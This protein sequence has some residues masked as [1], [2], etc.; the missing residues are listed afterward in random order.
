MSTREQYRNSIDTLFPWLRILDGARLISSSK[1]S[2]DNENI[3]SSESNL[4]QTSCVEVQASFVPLSLESSTQAT[5][6]TD[7]EAQAGSEAGVKCFVS[8]QTQKVIN[9]SV[10]L[11]TDQ[12]ENVAHSVQTEAEL[13]DKKEFDILYQS[14]KAME[15]SHSS[16]AVLLEIDALKLRI[17]VLENDKRELLH[18][19]Q[20]LTKQVQRN[21][22][23]VRIESLEKLIVAQERIVA[24]SSGGL[25]S[26][27]LL[28]AWRKQV[29]ALM[30]QN[31]TT[32]ILYNKG[33]FD[34]QRECEQLKLEL[35]D[36]ENKIEE[37]LVATK[38]S[39]QHQ[40]D[41]KNQVLDL[42]SR[43]ESLQHEKA[44]VE[45]LL[46]QLAAR[47]SKECYGIERIGDK[48]GR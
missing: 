27:D 19:N 22:G 34:L 20:M 47:Y 6:V 13:V 18:E 15:Q 12:L 45:S 17:G 3:C 28:A 11:Q 2:I 39:H 9:R 46:K 7:Q 43:C 25:V 10:D 30:V 8:T 37:T 23:A 42:Q 38:V 40:R 14:F 29:Y 4:K 26:K 31:R 35:K 36:R 48:I 44:S 21:D 32:E 16:G 24:I 41:F 1:H 5:L 33:R